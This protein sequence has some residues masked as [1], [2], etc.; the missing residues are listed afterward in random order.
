MANLKRM[1]PINAGWL[2]LVVLIGLAQA[3][4]Q[5][6][7]WLTGYYA[8]YNE[9]VM[10][11]SQVDYTKLTHIIY[12]P[13]IP[14]TDGTLNT[15]PFGAPFPSD[16]IDLVTRAHQAGTKALLGIGG[17]QA[18][19]A[20]AG[21]TASTTPANL[22]KFVN[23]IVTVMQ[24]YDFDGVDI[25][26][27]AI[28][29][30][31]GDNTKFP[32]FIAALRAKLNTI[33][34][35]PML[36]MAPETYENGGRPD[37]IGPI[38]ADFDQL[39]I[40]TYQM[41]FNFCGWET[42]FNSP[43]NNS[44]ATFVLVPSEALPSI[45]NAITDYTTTHAHIPASKLAMGMQFDAEVW[46]GGSGTSTGGVTQPKQTW[47]ND[48]NCN[49]NSGAPKLTTMP[50]RQMSTTV[51]TNPNYTSH[52]D[53]VADQSWLS[54]DPSGAGTTNEANDRF[55]SYDGTQSIAKKGVDLS[56]ALAGVGGSLGGAFVFELSGDFLAAQPAAGQHPLLTAA[57]SMQY[58]LPGQL[59][60]LSA[61]AGVTSIALNWAAAPFA[62]SYNVYTET[63][64][65]LTP[66]GTP[67]SVT[68]TTAT[69]SGLTPGTLY[70]FLVEPVDVFGA[71]APVQT[72]ATPTG[73]TAPA[74]PTGLT[75]AAGVYS[76]SLAWSAAPTATS[77][78]LERSTG[79]GWNW[80]KTLTGTTY[81][82]TGLTAGTTYVY[83]VMASNAFGASGISNE[84]SATPYSSAPQVPTGLKA[85][86]S[87]TQVTLT[88]NTAPNATGYS[89]ARSPN[90]V[91][92]SVI[93]TA[94]TTSYTD[95]NVT[96]GATYYY[97][98]RSTAGAATSAFCSPIKV[99]ALT[100][101]PA[102]TG[103]TAT[104]GPTSIQ[105][106]WNAVSVATSYTL[107]RSTGS[108]WTWSKTLTTNSYLDTGLT[109]GTWYYYILTAS[110][111]AGVS[112]YSSEASAR[113]LSAALAA[114]TALKA[115]A[116]SVGGAVTLTWTAPAGALADYSYNVYQ[117]TAAGQEAATAVQTVANNATT[118]TL[119][120]L[121]TNKNYYFT[122]KTSENGV[123]SAASSEAIAVPRVLYVP[124]Y[125]GQAV[126]VRVGGGTTVT[127]VSFS[128]PSC[129]PNSLAVNRNKLY[130]VCNSDFGN[131][132]AILVYDA[133]KIRPASGTLTIAPIKT[134]TSGD[135]NSLIGMAFDSSNDLWVASNGNS[136][137][138]EFT[139]AQ[140][141][142]ATPTD[143]VSLVDSPS[144]PVGLA[145]DTDQ[146]L[147]VTGL[148]GDGILLNFDPSQFGL[149]GAA[150]PR[151]CAAT[152]ALGGI[153]IS[154]PNL[155]LQPEGVAVFKGS[156]WVANN[157]TTGSNG[158]GGATPG[159]ELVNLAV[160]NG[161]L[162]VKSVY[163]SVVPDSGGTAT[164]PF[165]CPGG[166]F[167]SSNQL[168]VNDESY[169]EANPQ[170]GANGDTASATGGV[171][172]F[173]VPQLAAKL[174]AK[175]PTFAKVTGRP[176]FGGIF[177]E[178][179]R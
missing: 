76:V 56:P 98:V 63:T 33:A 97:E 12:W 116:V 151:Y 150:N 10:S 101:T 139:A 77:Y 177:V 165:F 32:A 37:L 91:T 141:S 73:A 34:P 74:A 118:V 83:A 114:P 59:T 22:S 99:I 104:P 122:V 136:E 78:T 168:W 11:P 8:N 164:S 86:P 64:S 94:T 92:F 113:P 87:P 105:V 31:A 175:P 38:Y 158:L 115:T 137:I 121:A 42:W 16:A 129:N 66:T 124:D 159:R 156:V 173:T 81:T 89:I 152:D 134:I 13:L 178:N 162:A 132:D 43:L 176:G 5:T 49:S 123:L 82:D 75:A 117:G 167:A 102:P 135:F 112:A 160:S 154:Q 142:A 128:L 153:C 67:K 29:S 36:T 106:S 163:G 126:R 110:G 26:W 90:G 62:D 44:G 100:P 174:V 130:V 50:Y 145:F 131:A 120:G 125:T 68:A 70:Y 17:D 15:S 58:L 88:W 40:Q 127:S 140:L 171:F 9:G 149:Q 144:S 20:S 54:Y 45:T 157:S 80:T 21:F 95:T 166:L 79:T 119:T 39:N 60:T 84:A 51:A 46:T 24:E 7:H 1:F 52:F 27:E 93:G 28:G 96:S 4:A 57:H 25:N 172:S 108:G 148:F 143:I 41:S 85:A 155:F 48:S 30:G 18:S 179:D 6:D 35:R 138:L 133:T 147:W 19:G 3:K 61:A 103:V 53:N 47:T 23:N 111:P 161:S 14:N 72:S 146:S 169:G 71:G 55:I 2:F 107:Q 170:C 109:A 69:I 65:S